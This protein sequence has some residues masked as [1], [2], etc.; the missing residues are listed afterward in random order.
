MYSSEVKQLHEGRVLRY[1]LL[2]DEKPLTWSDVVS[3][4][5]NDRSFVCFFE[6]ILSDAP[7][8][9]YFWETPPVTSTTLSRDFEFVLVDSEQLVGVAADQRAFA[10]HFP[11]AQAGASVVQFSNISGDATLVVPCPCGP[12]SAYAQIST[13]ARGAPDEQQHQLW[14]LVGATLE[15][16]LGKQPVW[17]STSGLGVYWLHIRL[18]SAPK[19]Y[20]HEPYRKS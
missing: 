3:R 2:F 11:S 5:Q 20:T 14:T 15:R 16:R 4:W 6:S 7:F 17:L 1:Q 12:L 9:A 19:Y 8:P 13:F 10:N 18:D